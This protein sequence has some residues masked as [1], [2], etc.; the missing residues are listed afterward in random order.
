MLFYYLE[1][2]AVNSNGL[3]ISRDPHRLIAHA[4]SKGVKEAHHALNEI[5]PRGGCD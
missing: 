4:A 2:F 5:C 3:Y 1:N